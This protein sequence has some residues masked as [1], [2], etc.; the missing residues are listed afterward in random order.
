ML[1]DFEPS[2]TY[3]W[4]QSIAEIGLEIATPARHIKEEAHA[5]DPHA[6]YIRY[7]VPEISQLPH[8]FVFEPYMM[9]EEHQAQYQLYLGHHY[10]WP[11]IA[12]PPPPEPRVSLTPE[13]R[14][15]KIIALKQE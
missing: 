11:A 14:H 6:Q 1:I 13:E 9:T 7:W 8:Q 5:I 2:T 3:G 15:A 4:L 10:P 12:P